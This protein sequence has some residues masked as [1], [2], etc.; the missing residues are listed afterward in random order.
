MLACRER[1]TFIPILANGFA[2]HTTEILVHHA[3]REHGES[4]YSA[5]RLI[6][7][8]FNLLTCMTTMPLRI[9]TYF[10]L[11]AAFCGYLLSIYIVIRRFFW[12]DGDDWGQSGTF[13][14][15]AVMFI[16]TGIQMIGI[17]MIGEYIGRIY[18]DVRARPRY[19]IENIF[20]RDSKE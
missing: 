16:F 18:N 13:M 2:R 20:G 3:E 14:L 5:M 15:F 10:G 4:K 6:S 8:M 12:V 9:L 7:L 11:L 1:S 17:G 19:F